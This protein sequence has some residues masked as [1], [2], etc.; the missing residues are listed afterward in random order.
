MPA[1]NYKQ[2]DTYGI[3][4]HA[5]SLAHTC[6]Y[7]AVTR[8]ALADASGVPA[9]TI[10]HYFGTMVQLRRAI[11]SAAVDRRDLVVIAQGL[12]AGDSKAQAASRKLKL[13]SVRGLL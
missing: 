6:G 7:R 5:L 10:S 4:T 1:K 2:H 9:G 11:M 13:Q 12:A 3:L 8:S